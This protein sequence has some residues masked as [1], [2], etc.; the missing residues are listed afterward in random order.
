[1]GPERIVRTYDPPTAGLPDSSRY[2]EAM[3]VRASREAKALRLKRWYLGLALLSLAWAGLMTWDN[4]QLAGR[5]VEIARHKPVYRLEQALDGH[6]RLVLLDDALTPTKGVRLQAVSWWVRWWRRI[7]TDPVVQARD[8]AAAR[9]RL[10]Q[11]SERKWDALLARD[12]DP[13]GGW[14][15]DVTDLR[16]EEQSA[17]P[18]T[19]LSSFHVV[20]TETVYRDFKPQGRALMSAAVVTLDGPPRDGALDGVAVSGFSE[21]A[22]TPL[23]LEGSPNRLPSLPEVLP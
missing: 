5:L 21:P 12:L 7:G 6:Q 19:G 18:E 23:P 22:A 3:S 17:D 2:V 15:R 9:A 16:V 13:A 11:G 20:W 14:T 10:V 4:R 8:R 1:M